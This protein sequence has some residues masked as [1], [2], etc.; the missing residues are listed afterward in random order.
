[1]SQR[2]S[3][4]VSPAL[5]DLHVR[6]AIVDGQTVDF[7]GLADKA[8]SLGLDGLV[9]FGSDGPLDVRDGQA[10]CE[11]TGVHFYAGVELDTE[12][13]RLLCYPKELD[14]WFLEA[15]WRQLSSSNGEG[16]AKYPA[17]AVVKAFA[18]RGGAVVVAQPEQTDQ[19]DSSAQEAFARQQ[20]LSAMVIAND[21]QHMNG[22][23]KT[24]QAARSAKLACVAGSAGDASQERFGS[25]ATVFSSPPKTQALLVDSLRAGRVWPVEI[26]YGVAAEKAGG[27][28]RRNKKEETGS[29]DSRRKRSRNKRSGDD[30]RGNRL[31]LQATQ[32]VTNR[33]DNEQPQS[34]PIAMLYGRA[35]Q[36]R[37]RNQTVT[38]ETLD[39][40]NGN[41]SHGADPNVMCKPEFR[42][43]R[44]ERRHV[45][46][47]L[48]TID[49]SKDDAN[50][51]ALR[52]A[53]ANVGDA[54]LRPAKSSRNKDKRDSSRRR[55]RRRRR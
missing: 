1:M 21:R 17:E 11:K 47:L 45:N 28:R 3:S 55:G 18:E 7:G 32:A 12:G 33:Y 2:N 36:A 10:V 43:L 4:D 24:L 54:E 52:F 9:L 27:D 51:V 41:R 6:Q 31:E 37:E 48:A 49:H 5:V 13:G 16:T 8:L 25:V 19:G 38:D 35:D 15:G 30:N 39:R 23:N 40:V 53:I 26:G 29:T 42:E 44:A 34:D 14:A 22:G 20:G 50:S 46:L